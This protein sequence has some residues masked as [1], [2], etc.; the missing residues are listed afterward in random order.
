MEEKMGSFGAPVQGGG[1]TTQSPEEHPVNGQTAPGTEI[2]EFIDP[3]DPKLVSETL[4]ADVTKDAYATPPIPPDAKYRAK[5]KHEGVKDAAQQ[6]IPFVADKTKDGILFLK[7][8]ISASIIDPTGRFDGFVVR[9]Q[10]GGYVSTVLRKDKSSTLITLLSKVKKPDGTFWA[11]MGLRLDQR[12][13]MDL[14]VRALTGEPEV[15]IETVWEWN[16]QVCGDLAKASNYANGYPRGL[17]GMQRFP[18]ETDPEKRKQGFLYSP[19]A[20]C[21]VN[22]GHGYFRAYP[23]IARFLSLAEIGIK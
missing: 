19:E 11:T 9:P 3:N 23:K 2:Q 21:Q 12:S 10:F 14:L 5:L 6:V 20:R 4:D 7:T 17:S 16:C 18:Q 15:G 8:Q 1:H 13:W 22:P